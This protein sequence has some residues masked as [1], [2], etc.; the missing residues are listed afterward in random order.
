MLFRSA[1]R[2]RYGVSHRA[3]VLLRKRAADDLGID[4]AIPAGEVVNAKSAGVSGAFGVRAGG[5]FAK[6]FGYIGFPHTVYCPLPV[7]R[8]LL[9]K[10]PV[11]GDPDNVGG[12]SKTLRL[13]CVELGFGGGC[14]LKTGLACHGVLRGPVDSPGPVV[15]SSSSSLR[16]SLAPASCATAKRCHMKYRVA[17]QRPKQLTWADSRR[18]QRRRDHQTFSV[19]RHPSAAV[20]SVACSSVVPFVLRL[21]YLTIYIIY[22][23]RIS[24]KHINLDKT[25]QFLTNI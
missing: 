9:L 13:E 14:E 25:Y 5:L 15:S 23:I 6:H 21:V 1:A 12:R 10:H 24:V 16:K 4:A 22:D 7:W 17:R 20:G 18:R 2:R 3:A 8:T 19:F 11:D